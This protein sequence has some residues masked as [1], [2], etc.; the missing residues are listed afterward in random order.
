MSIQYERKQYVNK[1]IVFNE[2]VPAGASGYIDAELDAWGEINSMRVRFAAGENGTLHLRPLVIIPPDLTG[3]LLQYA[4]GSNKY[5][6]GDDE[7]ITFDLKYEIE[8]H[9]K[10]R[11][12]YENTATDADSADSIVNVVIG[13]TYYDI[14]EPVD[15]VGPAPTTKRR[16][17]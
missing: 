6:S 11:L 3:D 2:S 8:N 14:V 1:S 9:A 15:L 16:W 17:F 10:I 4:N 13:V 7:N 5:I 12:C